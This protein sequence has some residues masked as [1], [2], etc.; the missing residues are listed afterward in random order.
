MS[1]PIIQAIE[2][3]RQYGVEHLLQAALQSSALDSAAKSHA[4]RLPE[5]RT[6]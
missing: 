1:L 4:L 6:S 5:G 2:N 3:V